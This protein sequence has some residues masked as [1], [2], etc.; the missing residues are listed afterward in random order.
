MM[1]SLSGVI[2]NGQGKKNQFPLPWFMS[3]CNSYCIIGAGSR[4]S[5][6]GLRLWAIKF[7]IPLGLVWEFLTFVQG[8][9]VCIDNH[10]GGTVV[11]WE[12]AW[13]IEK[14]EKQNPKKEGSQYVTGCGERSMR[15]LGL[16]LSFSHCSCVPDLISQNSLSYCHCAM[17][18][19]P[20]RPI[21]D[22]ALPV[23]QTRKRDW[24][25][26][27]CTFLALSPNVS[28]ESTRALFPS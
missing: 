22:W 4:K 9:R 3:S 10:R 11:K 6:H 21:P 25:K 19:C 5:P 8:Y 24:K 16:D 20:L 13:G 27:K 18:L 28:L 1:P 26:R 7:T 23:R 2:M 14:R 15:S 12:R 17:T